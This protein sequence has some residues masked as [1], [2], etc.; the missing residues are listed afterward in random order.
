MKRIFA[1]ILS[2]CIVLTLFTACSSNENNK[3]DNTDKKENMPVTGIYTDI[4]NSDY[5]LCGESGDLR[6]S[7]QPSTTQI[8]VENL[9]DGSLWYSNPQNPQDDINASQLIKMRM[10]SVLDIEY[11]NTT[12]KKRT[13]INT[14]TSNVKSGKYE[15]STVENG[16]MFKYDVAEVG[17]TVFLVV[18]LEKDN[19]VT[20]FWYEDSKEKKEDVEIIHIAP[21]PYFVRGSMEDN[22]YLFL[23]DGSGATVDFSNVVYSGNPYSR[24]IY[25]YEPTL[26]TSDYYLDVAKN[27]VYLPVFGAKVNESAVMAICENGAEYGVLTAEACGQSSSYARAYVNYKLLN[28]V[29]YKVGN[30]STELFDTVGSSLQNIS[31]RYVFLSGEDASYS[32]MA[33]KYRDYLSDG[34]KLKDTSTGFYTDIY[35]SVIKKTST[36]G[37]PHNK[38]VLLTDEKELE[39]IV[40]KL[41]SEGIKDITVRY[42]D[43]NTDEIKGN[44]VNGAASSHGISLKKINSIKNARIYPAILDLHTYSNGG[45]LDR[46]FN[47]SKSITQLPF[48]WKEYNLSNLNETKEAEYRVSVEWFEKNSKELIDKL[49]AKNIGNIAFGDVSNNLYCD[50]KDEGFKRDKTML[51][52]QKFIKQSKESF[53]S[54]MLDS[55]N[56]YAAIFADV[57][58]NTPI[59]HSNHDILSNSVPFYTIALSGIVDCVAPAY[60][61]GD[62]DK[63]VL[64]TVASGASLCV[65]WMWEDVTKLSGTGLAGLSNVNFG[66]TVNECLTLYK[67]I[68]GVYSGINGSRIYSHKY[69]N[70]EVSVTEYENG[71]EIYV[72]FGKEPFILD[73]GTQIPA[74]D[75]VAKEGK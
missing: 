19:L 69:I 62:N 43:W 22:G 18:C 8:K 57:I 55:A 68:N 53:N 16:V 29:E 12:T 54:L 32:G 15:I 27:S 24:N 64:Y 56:A 63:N 37:I 41:H 40:E 31:I 70:E 11:V 71:L 51:V 13:L 66:E 67:K 10:M 25:G 49:K 17:K 47:A 14:Y 72:N 30:Y 58:Y 34:V 59:D 60:N 4:K 2:I 23:P 48:S 5:V 45:Y 52:M 75:F 50:F 42:R 38:T 33:R 36:L 39:K 44:K 35:A 3:G 6:L 74:E 61:N 73:D 28:S 20:R 65:G 46:L 7:F 21:F 26:I 1:L 9:K